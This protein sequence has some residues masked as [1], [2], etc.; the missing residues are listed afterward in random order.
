IVIHDPTAWSII[1]NF[2]HDKIKSLPEVEDS[3]CTHLEASFGFP[4][5]KKA[6]NAVL[7]AKGDMSTAI[8][9]VTKLQK[10]AL[11]KSR[12]IPVPALVAL[13]KLKHV[14]SE[15][16][17]AVD[18]LHDQKHICGTRPILKDLLNSIAEM[19]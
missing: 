2:V 4:Q 16:M 6:F 14:E 7:G 9:A 12:N 5:W 13:S 1:L 10:N 15:L 17:Q 3:L 8:T 19:E 11:A 18:T